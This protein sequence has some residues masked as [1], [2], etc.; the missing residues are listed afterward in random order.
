MLEGRRILLTGL[1]GQVGG[2][3]AEAL[4]PANEVWGFARFSAAG[5][6]ARFD[7][8]GVR[9]VKGDF[10]TGEF[11]DLPGDFDVV[12]HLAA[13]TT[14][15][16]QEVG[17]VQNAEG[18]GLLM[19]H[20]RASK[21]F[22]H[23]STLGVIG[24][25][26][27][28]LRKKVETDEI[29]GVTPHSPNYGPTKTA[30]EGVARTLCRLYG[31]PTTIARIHCAYGGPYD[32]GGL[33]GGMLTKI[34]A[35]TPVRLS[36]SRRIHVTPVHEDDM[37]RHLEPLI[38]AASVPAFIVHWGG[39]EPVALEDLANYIGELVGVAP[40]FEWSEAGNFPNT[41]L[42]TSRGASIGLTWN[43]PWKEGVRRMIQARRPD[44]VLR[45]VA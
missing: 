23:V 40:I 6:Q 39:N 10:T 31:L 37:L 19:H 15:G 44:I 24:E 42:D 2:A 9:T 32:D 26:A 21:A 8:M 22:V 41:L 3:F 36:P 5:S 17:M 38:K 4:A 16:T 43:I 25:H 11:A 14:P 34:L 28:P 45:D 33:P 29:S 20:C 30:A 13:N 1:T 12:I 35:G 27:D 18:T 7:A